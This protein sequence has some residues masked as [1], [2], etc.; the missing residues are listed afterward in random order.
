M[1]FENKL[2]SGRLIKRYKRFF[3]DVKIHGKI[4]TAHCPNTGSMYGLL[5]KDNKV[6]LTKS[7]NPNRKLKYTLQIIQDKKIKVGVNTHLSNKIVMEALQNNLIKEFEKKIEIKPETKFGANT[8]FDFLITK[9]NFKAFIEVKNVTLSRKKGIAEFPDAI[10]S[11]GL[12]HIKELIK[13]YEKGYKIYILY[14]IQRNDCKSF[15]IAGDIDPE[16]S[17]SLSKAVKKKL[18]IL[19]FDCKFSSK[20]IKLNQKLKFKI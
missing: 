11:R 4:I 1:N 19:C 3:V 9:N 8:R 2:I 12:K 10:T 7:N 5:K 15:K 6:W 20:G 16:Y 14:L 13:A 18:N 17:N